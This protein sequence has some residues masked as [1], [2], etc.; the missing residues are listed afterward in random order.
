MTLADIIEAIAS[1]ALLVYILASLRSIRLSLK[2]IAA[3]TFIIGEAL[4]PDHEIFEEYHMEIGGEE[5]HRDG[6]GGKER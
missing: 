1:W 2:A 6:D 5:R 4:A 3:F